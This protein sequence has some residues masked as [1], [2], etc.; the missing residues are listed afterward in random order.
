MGVGLAVWGWGP[1]CGGGADCM[2]MG[3]AVGGV[4]GGG[5]L[6]VCMGLIVWG[7]GWLCADAA[8]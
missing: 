4:D 5:E 6:M 3:L 8:G 1:L 2:G 7:W